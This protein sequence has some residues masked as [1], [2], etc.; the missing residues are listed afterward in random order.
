MKPA[1][2]FCLVVILLCGACKKIEVRDTVNP[3]IPGESNYHVYVTN[4]GN[5]QSLNAEVSRYDPKDGDLDK[6]YYALMN[7]GGLLGDVCQS[8]TVSNEFVYVVMNNSSRIEVI[9]KTDF[10][11]AGSITGLTSPRYLVIKGDKGFVSDLY[12]DHLSVINMNTGQITGTVPLRGWTEEM[13][14]SGDTLW[15]TNQQAEYV[16]LVNTTTETVMDS[17]HTGYASASIR[18]DSNGFIWVL[19]QGDVN[20]NIPATLEK[21]DPQTKITTTF[22][23]PLGSAR[24]QMNSSGTVLYFLADGIYRTTTDA[25][26]IPSQPWI[27]KESRNL[28]GLGVDPFTEDI[29]V[30]DVHDFASEGTVYHY[31]KDKMLTRTFRTNVNPNGFYFF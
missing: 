30:S 7:N 12:A 17:I 9:S 8:I 24:L 4:E 10:K 26:A 20:L 27:M 15:V 28:Y 14:L 5:F 23:I 2:L 13:L 3:K 31:T 1:A 6:S 21:I 19:C 22:S 11:K 29:Y 18:K 16:Y 25:S